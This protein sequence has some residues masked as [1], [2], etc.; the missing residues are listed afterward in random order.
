MDGFSST[1]DA[2]Q[3]RYFFIEIGAPNDD[4]P[5]GKRVGVEC[6]QRLTQFEHDVISN[7]GNIIDGSDTDRLQAVAQPVR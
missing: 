6:M 3:R 4:L 7:I 5:A 2:V 1:I